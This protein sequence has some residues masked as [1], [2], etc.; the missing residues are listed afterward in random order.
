MNRRQWD[1]YAED[2]HSFIISPFQETVSNPIFADIKKQNTSNLVAA[3]IGTG[4]GDFLP[5]LSSQFK[6]VHAIDFSQKMLDKAKKKNSKLDN[7]KFM[8]GDI[9]KLG[10]L[11]IK[12]DVAVAA[13][14]ILHPLVKDVE[15]S[16]KGIH[17][18]LNENGQFLGIFPSMESVLYHFSLVYER[19]YKKYKNEQKALSNTKRIVERRK[20]NFITSVYDDDDEKQ[21]FYYKF[22]LRKRLKEAAFKNIRFKKVVYPWGKEVGDYEDF[23]NE[24]GMWDWYVS[25][26]K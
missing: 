2:Y 18:K 8:Q 1:S 17:D 3:D 26:S 16:L 7:V 20:Y 22:E 25:A 21:K 4:R 23:H 10:E 13:N 15:K 9:R 19:E 11:N 6:K 5:F 14:S 12:P 24:P